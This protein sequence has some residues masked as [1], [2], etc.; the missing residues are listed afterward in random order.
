MPQFHAPKVLTELFHLI[1]L[2]HFGQHTDKGLFALKGGCNL[3]FFFGSLRYS[4]DLDLDIKTVAPGTLRKKVRRILESSL[5]VKN[6]SVHGLAIGD[7]TTPKQTDTVQRWK[8]R[9]VSAA[10]RLAIPTKI[11]FSRRGLE[12][13]IEFGP[14]NPHLLQDYGLFPVMV[15]HYG[16]VA[17]CRQKLAALVHRTKT[18]ARDVFD[19]KWLLD[20]GADFQG[21]SVRLKGDLTSAIR[22]IESLK[23]HDYK[24]QVVAY[25]KP[26]AQ[27]YYGSPRVW[28]EI[29]AT[30]SQ[31]LAA[32]GA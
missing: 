9:I 17:A 19:L 18:Q 22:N 31:R 6:L 13:G 16:L 23:F 5:F 3:R 24:G 11:E 1:F 30:V 21:L 8:C 20:R 27:D 12:P 32:A 28:R 25:L 15:S 4:E 14:V 29:V 2:S 26:E 10:G 7:V